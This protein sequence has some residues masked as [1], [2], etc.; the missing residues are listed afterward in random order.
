MGKD[1]LNR[2]WVLKAAG[3]YHKNWNVH[4][5]KYNWPLHIYLCFNDAVNSAEYCYELNKLWARVTMAIWCI[6]PA[7]TCAEIYE[8]LG[9]AARVPAST[10]IRHLPNRTLTAIANL[11]GLA[12]RQL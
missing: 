4:K 8:N 12:G 6:T 3:H 1:I 9:H 11:L 5:G 10:R 7:F 2:D